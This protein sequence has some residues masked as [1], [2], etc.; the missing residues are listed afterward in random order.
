MVEAHLRAVVELQPMAAAFV[1]L[2]HSQRDSVVRFCTE[3]TYCRLSFVYLFIQA[4]TTY[5]RR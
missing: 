4:L 1:Q 5:A 3:L 2:P